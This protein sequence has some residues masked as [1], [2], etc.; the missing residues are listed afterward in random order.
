MRRSRL[1]LPA[2]G[3]ALLTACQG[4]SPEP[5]TEPATGDAPAADKAADGSLRWSE[6]V[7]WDGDL[8]ACRQG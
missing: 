1:L 3:L 4:R 6:S 2:L 5:G 8:N 7:V